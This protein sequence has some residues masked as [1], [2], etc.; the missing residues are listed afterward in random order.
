MPVAEAFEADFEALDDARARPAATSSSTSG[1]R[2]TPRS[3]ACP[4]PSTFLGDFAPFIGALDPA[5]TQLNPVLQQLAAYH[6]ELT[7]FFANIAVS[8]QA[9]LGSARL[10]TTCAR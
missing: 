10:C 4:P 5:L 2:R 6:S 9:T 1:R 8:T 3:R 7:A